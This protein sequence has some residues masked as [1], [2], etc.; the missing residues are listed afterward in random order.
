M[1]DK[2]PIK[3]DKSI[4]P[5]S[6]EHHH[7]LLLCWKIRKGLSKGIEPERIK[8]YADWH[9][10]KYVLPHFEIE[11]KYLFPV[12]GK[13]HEMIKKALAEHRRLKRLF[14]DN[15]S[16]EKSLSLIEEELEQHVRFEEREL[17][18]EIQRQ[19]TPEQLELIAEKHKDEKFQENTIDEF[20]I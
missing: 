18:N 12:L 8:K 11:E 16:I 14:K 20:W 4:Q 13:E 6:R 2:K 19:A 17:F 10:E 9:F 5:L 15:K 1:E 7:N 3:R